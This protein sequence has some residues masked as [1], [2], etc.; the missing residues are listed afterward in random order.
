MSSKSDPSISILNLR[1]LK[2]NEA[3]NSNFATFPTIY[4]LTLYY[5]DYL[6][7]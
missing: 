2:P 3:T 4:R 1:T 5:A 6:A 7:M